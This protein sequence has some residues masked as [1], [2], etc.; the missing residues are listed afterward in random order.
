MPRSLASL[1]P[2][3]VTGRPSKVY[4]PSSKAWMPAM[5]LIR[6]LLPAP[7]SPTRAVTWPGRTSMSTP[8]S[9]CTAP[10]LFWMPRRLSRGSTDAGGPVFS[11][12]STDTADLL[13]RGLWGWSPGTGGGASGGP[14]R[15][16]GRAARAGPGAR[17]PGSGDAGAAAAAVRLAQA[18]LVA[19]GLEVGRAHVGELLVAVVEHLL[20]VLGGDGDRRGQRGRDVHLGLGV[21]HGAGGQRVGLVLVALDQRDRQVRGGLGLEVGVLVDG[22]ALVAGEDGLQAL[23]RGVLAGDGDVTVAA[24]GLEPGDDAAGHRVVGGDDAV[25]FAVVLRVE[26]LEGRAGL[27]GVPEAALVAD[28]G[29]VTRVHLRLEG[30]LVALLEQRGVVVAR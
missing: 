29:V 19:G 25:D 6:V 13:V 24:H 10:K 2:C 5:P 8:R 16:G 1:G 28:E 23:D 17:A 22:H 4:S 20:H 21:R 30:L 3:T 26:L 9:T 7:L 27:R 15:L 12:A 14:C 18:G 11:G